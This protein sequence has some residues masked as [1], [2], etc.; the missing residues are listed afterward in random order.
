MP[1]DKYEDYETDEEHLAQTGIERL[2]DG[3]HPFYEKWKIKIP[4]GVFLF[5]N[6]LTKDFSKSLMPL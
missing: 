5:W 1:G 6:S 2:D 4:K 3:S